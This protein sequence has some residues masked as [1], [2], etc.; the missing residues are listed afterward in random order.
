MTKNYAALA[1][2]IKIEDITSEEQHQ[3]ILNKLKNN[4]ESFDELFIIDRYQDDN[5]Y[6][7]NDGE[8]KGWLGYFIGQNTKLQ[9]LYFYKTID[10]ESF[11]KEM[12]CNTSIQNVHFYGINVSVGKVFSMLGTLLKNNHNLTEISVENGELGVGDT[13][14]LSLAI[15]SCSKSLTTFELGNTEIRDGQLVDIVA[16]LSMHPQ[17]TTLNFTGMSIGRN[18]CTALSTLLRC[19]TT[20]LETL[21][22]CNNLIDDEGVECIVNALTNVN[23]LKELHLGSN[24]SFTIRGWRLVSTLLETPGCKLETIDIE[25]N[26]IGDDVAQLFAN[27]LANNS[28][29]KTLSLYGNSIT[30]EGWASFSK[31]LCDKSSVNKT[32]LSN[33]TLVN[34][35]LSSVINASLY[36]NNKSEDK[37]VVAMSKILKEHLISIRNPSLN[38]SLKPYRS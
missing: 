13:R 34:V 8:D 38:G 11:Y 19:T 22:L 31:L 12:S 4:D 3:T 16:A 29:L 36:A 32:Y 33:H 9:G 1:D 14:Q 17:L 10:N 35:G 21:N 24:R 18:E 6:V 30:A 7:P 15:G 2:T 5:D 20:Q 37:R 28:T 25:N 27:T 26:N 23:T